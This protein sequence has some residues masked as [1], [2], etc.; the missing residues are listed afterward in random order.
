MNKIH[1]PTEL[2]LAKR[3]A[4]IHGLLTATKWERAAII[5]AFTTNDGQ[6]RP[7]TGSSTGFP[8]PMERFAALGYAGLK[9]DKT[10]RH[11]RAAW[12]YAIEQGQAQPVQPGD[13]VELPDLG[14]PPRRDNSRWGIPHADEIVTQAKADGVGPVKALDVAQS[15]KA[16]ITAIKASPEV[17]KAVADVIVEKPS[18]LNAALD[19]YADRRMRSVGKTPKTDFDRSQ[20]KRDLL[21]DA[22]DMGDV[23][24]VL[25]EGSKAIA[26]L[27]A[28]RRA[29]DRSTRLD[30]SVRD[31]ALRLLSGMTAEITDA[32]AAL[33]ARDVDMDAEL[34][35]LVENYGA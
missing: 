5:Y 10:V 3:L 26:A 21:G 9:S 15:T 30:V 32:E 18:I 29:I 7:E 28:M 12:E 4:E 2:Q 35:K 25:D 17:A 23:M 11:Y 33:Q 19:D 1:I 24:A 14:W 20:E 22:A 34:A 6:G 27:R 8:M 13:D 31:A 16:M